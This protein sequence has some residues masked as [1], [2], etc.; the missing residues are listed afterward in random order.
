M[1]GLTGGVWLLASDRKTLHL[2]SSMSLSPYQTLPH[3]IQSGQGLVGSVA[4]QGRALHTDNPSEHPSYDPSQDRGLGSIRGSFLAVP[5]RADREVMGVLAI[6]TAHK[7]DIGD[8]ERVFIESVADI[9]GSRLS[10]MRLADELRGQLRQQ[11]AL[12]A[13]GREIACGLDLGG[14]LERAL[15]WLNRLVEV[16]AGFLWLADSQAQT[17]ELSA[18]HGVKADVGGGTSLFLDE[19]L[20]GPAALDGQTPILDLETSSPRLVFVIRQLLAC[21]LRDL[22]VVPLHYH[23]ELIGIIAMVNKVGAGFVVRDKALLSAAGDLIAVA[24]GN[25][26]LHAETVSLAKERERA[27]AA[28]L[29]A[30]RLATVGRLAASLSHEINN[31]MQTIRGALA[32]ALEDLEDETA[33]RNYMR[34]SM[35]GVDRVVQLVGRLR[36]IYRSSEEGARPVDINEAVRAACTYAEAASSRQ[37]VPLECALESGLPHVTGVFDQVHLVLLSLTLCLTDAL[38]AA[39][40]GTLH[41]R[42]GFRDEKVRVEFDTSAPVAILNDVLEGE[43]EECLTEVGVRLAFSRDII[44]AMDGRMRLEKAGEAQALTV[45][46]PVSH[47]DPG[48]GTHARR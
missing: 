42:T 41:I 3:Q 23:G 11:G 35:D 31:P 48:R 37:G 19:R 46:F 25:A 32:L 10:R 24:V 6:G 12:C 47:G 18:V 33:V 43:K 45:E 13:M 29:R 40:G 9:A 1:D 7:G 5:L 39:G 4:S 2:A 15:Q 22:A 26:R 8:H 38:G 30:T 36:Q 16:E 21:E 34:M 44:Q 14:T 28:A 17:L 20:L 27:H